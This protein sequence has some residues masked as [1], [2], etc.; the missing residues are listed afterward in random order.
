MTPTPELLRFCFAHTNAFLVPAEVQHESG[1]DPE[2]GDRLLAEGRL[3]QARLSCLDRALELCWQRGRDLFA[4]APGS[5]FPPRQTNLLVVSEPRG[6]LPYLEPFGGTSSLIY[7]SDLDVDPEYVAYLL[8]HMERLALLRSVRSTLVCNLS[9]W[10]DRDE[11]S[12]RAFARAAARAKRPDARCFVALAAS[13]AWIDQLL[14]IPLRPPL[15]EPTEA[16][17]AVEGAD[18]YIPKRLQPQVTA[19]CDEGEAALRDAMQ[20]TAPAAAR[21][22]GRTLD[23]LCDWLQQSRAHVIVMA[24]DTAVW[25]PT[26][27]DVR[28]I[29]G[30]LADASDAAVASVHADLEVV[31]ERSR[32]FLDR[33]RDVDA[34]PTQCA[35]LEVGGG[36]YVDASR[37][38]V[39]YEL[40]QPG[41][42][43]RVAAA[44]PYHRLLLGARV[45]HEWGHVAHAAKILRIPDEKRAAYVEARAALGEQFVHAL[46]EVPDRLRDSVQ[47]EARGISPDAS[48][49][50]AALARK[51]L[52]R[53]GDY[54]S[55]LLSSRLI[56]AEEMQAYV[57]T[58]VR[59]HLDENLGVIS[60]LARYAY[61]IHYLE[62]A[63]LPR[64]YF[65][66]TSR[67]RDYFIGSGII[68]EERAHELFDAAGRV[69]ACYA[70]DEA[71]LE[72]PSA[73]RPAPKVASVRQRGSV[74]QFIPWNA[75]GP[76]LGA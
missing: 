3:S 43:A 20:A 33:V 61:E 22:T 49:L 70:I 44:P 50:P 29:R 71:R 37:R 76:T 73:E 48:G 40:Q 65:L 15:Q 60:E 25:S 30:A 41:F 13:F 63:G 74:P 55:N 4:R 6:I 42:D 57:R 36:A 26:M 14:H 75:S 34:L 28:W 58:N 9:Y 27:T 52:A 53:V 38:A 64:S 66:D 19:L 39:V 47:A 45:M 54:L 10:L 16:F 67:F 7:T 1:V 68:S 46:A 51:T 59:H 18:L 23:A 62:L 21:V 11:G 32:Q 8:I 24:A 12:R 35:V 2:F 5:W 69:L 72:L 31:H 56:P 17:L